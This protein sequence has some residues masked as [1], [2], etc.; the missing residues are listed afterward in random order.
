MVVTV[1]KGHSKVVKI[2][3][4]NGAMVD[5]QR[6]CIAYCLNACLFKR[7][8]KVLIEN[9]ARIDLQWS[10]EHSPLMIGSQG[11]YLGAARKWCSSRPTDR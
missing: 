11:G 3:L 5:M 4:E 10:K 6:Y 2:L 1:K 8:L 7:V 9:G